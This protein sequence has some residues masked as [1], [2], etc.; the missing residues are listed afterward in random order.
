[1]CSPFQGIEWQVG[2]FSIPVRKGDLVVVCGAP[3]NVST[4]LVLAKARLKGA[5]TIWWGQYWCATTETHRH[6]LRMKLSRLA[7]ALLFYTDAEVA[8]FQ[9]DGW[10]HPGPR[11]CAQ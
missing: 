1:M 6:R 4:L 8:R 7:D 3:R 9:A 2:A 11:R 5:R 10:T